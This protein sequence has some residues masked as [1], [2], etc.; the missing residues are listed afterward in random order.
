MQLHL[1]AYYTGLEGI[2]TMA[3]MKLANNEE[4]MSRAVFD[5]FAP[6][7]GDQCQQV[8]GRDDPACETA[9]GGTGRRFWTG[10]CRPLITKGR[11]ADHQVLDL[12]DIK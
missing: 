8:G 10:T 1:P 4:H 3:V 12:S 5:E 11:Q 2:G 6:F 9:G 7:D